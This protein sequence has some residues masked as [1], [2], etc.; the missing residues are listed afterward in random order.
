MASKVWE[1]NGTMLLIPPLY[2]VFVFV[3]LAA[4]LMVRGIVVERLA[5][6]VKKIPSTSECCGQV[7][8]G[9][10]AGDMLIPDMDRLIASAPR[11]G[12]NQEYKT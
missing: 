1:H 6:S 3:L 9:A 4:Q 8:V 2:C 10:R 5:K 12:K 7:I 11:N